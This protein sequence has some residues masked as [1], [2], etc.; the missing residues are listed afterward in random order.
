MRNNF[1][2]GVKWMQI[3]PSADLHKDGWKVTNVV[4]IYQHFTVFA[5]LIIK[6]MRLSKP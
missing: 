4:I 2:R 3:K 1:I 6:E 5:N